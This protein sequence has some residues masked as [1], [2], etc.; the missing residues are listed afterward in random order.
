MGHMIVILVP[1][2]DSWVLKLEKSVVGMPMVNF[3][4]KILMRLTQVEILEQLK[5]IYLEIEHLI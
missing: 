3:I 5:D 1:I 4:L 2:R